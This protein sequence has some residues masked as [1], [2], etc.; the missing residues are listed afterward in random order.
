MANRS[1]GGLQEHKLA[2][3]H[4]HAEIRTLSGAIDALRPTI[5]LGT[6]YTQCYIVCCTDIVVT[7]QTV[8]NP[9]ATTPPTY[10]SAQLCLQYI[11]Q[12][13]VDLLYSTDLCTV[14]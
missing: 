7:S 10:Y 1:T 8:E 2:Y 5:L 3:A 11:Q 9:A 6:Y 12:Y 4:E 13:I 14:G